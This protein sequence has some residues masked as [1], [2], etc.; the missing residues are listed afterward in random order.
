MSILV[1]FAVLACT[2]GATLFAVYCARTLPATHLT[3]ASKEVIHAFMGVVTLQATVVL[4]LL[5]YSAK[6]SFD[7]K[8]AEFRHAS[9]KLVLLDRVLAHYG[10][11]VSEARKLLRGAVEKEF[12]ETSPR[13]RPGKQGTFAVIETVQDQLRALTPSTE[14]Q[15]WLQKRALDVSGDIA[16]TR[17][18]LI[19]DLDSTMPM[20]F[21]LVLVFWLALIFFCFGLFAPANPT[22][23]TVIFLCAVS[24][25]ASV[26]LVMEMDNSIDGPI[27]IS[28][29]PLHKAIDQLGR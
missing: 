6:T 10:P 24:L 8:D 28:L 17:W 29:E 5:I 20:P 4:G 9:A 14:A 1:F 18:F 3:G 7:T 23:L 22:V 12:A 16:Q 11:E 26:Y 25:A 13:A 21:L 2:F 19:D 27:S 15:R